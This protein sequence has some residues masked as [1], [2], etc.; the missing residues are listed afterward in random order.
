MTIIFSFLDHHEIILN[1]HDMRNIVVFHQPP[2]TPLHP[3]T[4][5]TTPLSS[6]LFQMLNYLNSITS[7]PLKWRHS[8][9]HIVYRTKQR[10]FEQLRS[11]HAQD[12]GWGWG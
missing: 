3:T 1:N 12:E 4:P 7:T 11:E 9:V 2:P 10:L 8:V 6:S 5:L